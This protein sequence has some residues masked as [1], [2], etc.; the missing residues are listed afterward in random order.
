MMKSLKTEYLDFKA[1]C[2]E[3]IN[4]LESRVIAGTNQENKIDDLLQQSV[5]NLINL[6]RLY[7]TGNNAKQRK[8]IGSIFLEKVLFDGSDFRTIRE[9]DP[10][11]LIF[12]VDKAF[13]K[14]KTAQNSLNSDL[15]RVVAGTGIEPVFA[16]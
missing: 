4:K 7:T 9:S 12:T 1:E 6:R 2:E 11:K 16:P 8:I 3:E 15:C 10:I 5:D 13:G 14:I